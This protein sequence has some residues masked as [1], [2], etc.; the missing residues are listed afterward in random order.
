MN[1]VNYNDVTIII[2]AKNEAISIEVVLSD[3]LSRY[4]GA[5]VIVVDDGSTDGTDTIVKKFDSVVLISHKYSKG[6]GAAIK[7]GAQSA[8]N[9]VVVFMDGDGQ[10]SPCDVEKLL[11]EI[12]AG[13]D[14]AVGA[15]NSVS[16]ASI[17]R[18]LAN[19][20]YNKL[21][22][23]M[24]G[25]KVKDLTSGL[26]AVKKELFLK[27]LFMLPNKFSYPTTI[28]MA[29]FKNGHSISYVPITANKRDGKSH[30]S[31][32]K[33]GIRFLIIIFKV[34]TLYSP[35]KFFLPI[36]LILAS[37]G[38]INYYISYSASGTFTNMSALLL[39]ASLIV[40][41]FGFIGEQ[42]TTLFYK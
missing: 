8:K 25:F 19:K 30:I 11:A 6:N 10:H 40:C 26:R 12:H 4:R 34:G 18:L 13:Y 20:L 1:D 41:L 38:F 9:N 31:P 33:D 22:S 16:Q 39:L 15:R 42:I 2:P 17:G 27:Y 3:L 28:T 7:T 14:M 29:F 23:W 35:I 21:A 24:V 36:S 37:A 5:E 32:L